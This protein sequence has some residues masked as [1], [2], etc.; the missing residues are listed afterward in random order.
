MDLREKEKLNMERGGEE[1]PLNFHSPYMADSLPF[2]F[3]PPTRP[4][5]P[6]DPGFIERAARFSSFNGF[7]PN[8]FGA[9]DPGSNGGEASQ[10]GGEPELSSEKT[11]EDPARTA[12]KRKRGSLVGPHNSSSSSSSIIH[13]HQLMSQDQ[14]TD[15]ARADSSKEAGKV[16]VDEAP[17]EDYIHVRAR[18]GQATN[19]HSL[20]ERVRTRSWPS[21]LKFLIF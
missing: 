20:A 14:E 16:V 1:N 15:Q 13:H 10:S 9:S 7:Y 3:L 11:G 8:S 6:D 18:R 2:G 12:R 21:N 5:F 4:Q 17:K 19:S